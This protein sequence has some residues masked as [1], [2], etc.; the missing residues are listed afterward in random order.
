MKKI[1]FIGTGIMGAAM[2]GHLLDAGY[3]L[4][5]YNRTK[6][7]AQALLDRGAKWSDTP[8]ECAKG[9]E[10]II[11]MVGY[12]KDVE[13]IYL[14]ENSQFSFCDLCEKYL[15]CHKQLLQT[16]NVDPRVRNFF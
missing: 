11:S 7:K 4:T 9:Q 13:E 15:N 3:E 8:G 6:S 5:V 2:A 14:G 1:G 10:A 16:E 12:P